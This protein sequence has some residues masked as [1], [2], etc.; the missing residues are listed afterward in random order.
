MAD[1]KDYL[2]NAEIHLIALRKKL[3]QFELHFLDNTNKA[4]L[5][6]N[7]A[8]DMLDKSITKPKEAK[9][10]Y[11]VIKNAF[12]KTENIIKHDIKLTSFEMPSEKSQK[13]LKKECVRLAQLAKKELALAY[14]LSKT[15]IKAVS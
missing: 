3:S 8:F 5:E 11:A 6:L 7:S 1:I 4:L 2:K 9:K 15:I 10:L 14:N 12:A 13:K